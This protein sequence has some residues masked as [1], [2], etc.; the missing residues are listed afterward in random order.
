MNPLAEQMGSMNPLADGMGSGVSTAA[1]ILQSRAGREIGEAG[2]YSEPLLAAQRALR[3][4]SEL[5]AERRYHEA[6]EQLQLSRM[7]SGDAERIIRQLSE[8]TI[9]ERNA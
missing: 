2:N 5:A 1:S 8:S 3:R 4:A 7:H 6:A 9:G